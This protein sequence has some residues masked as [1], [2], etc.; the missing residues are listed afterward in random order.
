MSIVGQSRDLGGGAAKFRKSNG[1]LN[2]RK[3]HTEIWKERDG[4]EEKKKKREEGK[5]EKEREMKKGAGEA[6]KKRYRKEMTEEGELRRDR[7]ELLDAT[8]L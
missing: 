2:S 8:S 6:R 3:S 4:S 7:G 1:R 5:K